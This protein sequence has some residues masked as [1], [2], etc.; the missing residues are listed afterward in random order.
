[1][2]E[3][4]VIMFGTVALLMANRIVGHMKNAQNIL[5]VYGGE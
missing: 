4:G 3:W 2:F 5:I 1:M